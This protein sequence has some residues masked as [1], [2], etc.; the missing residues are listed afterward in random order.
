MRDALGPVKIGLA[1]TLLCLLLNIV[2]GVLFG[3]AEDMFQNF[4]KAG[5]TAHPALFNARS[6]DIIWRWFARAHFHAGGVG[7]FSLGMIILTALS[8]MSDG[9]KRLTAALI[10]LSIFY[11]LAWLTMSIVAPRIGT[12]A[13]H[14]YWL[15]VLC[16]YIG[17][18]TLGLG[19]AS[20][21]HG[22]FLTRS[23]PA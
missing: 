3:A 2:L 4:I 13:A 19:L 7:A 8:G 23:A 17:V 20:L 15:V 14:E 1:L 12:G 22:L 10:G 5:I 11:P 9:R 21:V 16:T 6:Q 18:G